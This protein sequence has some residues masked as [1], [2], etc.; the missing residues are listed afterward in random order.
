MLPVDHYLP[1]QDGICP[2]YVEERRVRIIPKK[3]K[4]RTRQAMHRMRRHPTPAEAHLWQRLRGDQIGG[5]RFRQ[6]SPVLGFIADFYCAPAQLVV[7]VDGGYHTTPEQQQYDRRRDAAF[8]N[9][10]GLNILRVTND[11]VLGDVENVL[12]LVRQALLWPKLPRTVRRR[13]GR[14]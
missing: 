11:Q 5:L 1:T 10:G 14:R 8:R 3:L 2:G 12:C 7:E 13:S 4:K 9:Q 6:Q